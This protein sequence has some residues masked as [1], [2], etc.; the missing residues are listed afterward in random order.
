MKKLQLDK[1]SWVVALVISLVVAIGASYGFEKITGD[2]MNRSLE[3][4]D[5]MFLKSRLVCFGRFVISVPNEAIIE[6]GA[7]ELDGS[8]T[9]Y[10]DQ[11][12]SLVEFS[13]SRIREARD[14]RKYLSDDQLIEFPLVGEATDGALPGQRL[15]FG[16][17]G[18]LGYTIHSYMPLGRDLFVLE[19]HNV[20]N[21]DARVQEIN[22][23]ATKLQLRSKA[24]IP[25]G[26]G[27]CIDGGFIDVQPKY[28]NSAFGIRFKEFPDV[29][30]SIQTR[31]NHDYLQEGSN[32]TAL[33]ESAK[34]HASMVQLATF[35][36]RITTLREGRRQLDGWEGEELLTRRPAYRDDT[37][38]HE[39]RFFSEGRRHDAL[40]PLLDIRMDTGVKDNARASVR[41]SLTNEAALSLWDKLLP[42][43]RVRQPSDATPPI[44]PPPT[45]S[46]GNLMKSGEICPQSGWWECL[47]QRKIDGERRRLIKAGDKLPTV[48]VDGGASFWNTLIGNTH[49]IAAVEWKLL[50]YDPPSA[51]SVDTKSDGIPQA[52]N[53]VKEN[54]A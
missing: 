20:S 17:K 25:V 44:A 50:E 40:H 18:T 36:S 49:Q 22:R 6:Y 47:E 3:K 8:L 48:L 15:V 34:E 10:R 26:P 52:N 39:F 1:N 9:V 7:A 12:D 4:I 13:S 19:I 54:D 21:K 29:R 23:F 32:P 24:E 16:A 5:E 35:F 51:F 27:F 31:K 38:A 30:F 33:R 14:E 37:D 11:V 53:D 46:L 41:P 42:T 45:V 28:E 2:L 43:I